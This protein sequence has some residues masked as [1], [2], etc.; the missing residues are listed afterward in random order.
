MHVEMFY[1]ELS[2]T[3][4]APDTA[5][6][7]RRAEQF[8]QLMIDAVGRGVKRGLRCPAEFFERPLAPE[9]SWYDWRADGRVD[10]EMRRYFRSLNTKMPFLIDL[11]DESGRWCELDFFHGA[12]NARGA[13]ACY[14]GDGLCVSLASRPE[15]DTPNLTLEIHEIVADE[16]QQRKESV[17]HACNTGHVATHDAWIQERITLLATSGDELWRHREE[18]FPQLIFCDSTKAQAEKLPDACLASIVRGLRALSAYCAKWSSGGFNQG[19][20]DCVVS[21]ES[22]STLALYAGERTFRCPDGANRVFELHAKLGYWRIHF[23]PDPGP[24]RLWIGYLGKHLRI[25]S[26]R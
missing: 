6:A 3:P 10:M 24:G 14:V 17:H 12:E 13:G 25:A 26:Q 2:S 21:G 20:V 11:P 4:V 9:Y 16:V 19:D 22:S 18:W 8:V 15:W 23:H 7:Q 1:N 5:T